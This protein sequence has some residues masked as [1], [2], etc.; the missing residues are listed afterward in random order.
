M[1]PGMDGEVA[2]F[3]GK[4][5][6]FQQ[7]I[8]GIVDAVEGRNG[9]EAGIDL[10]EKEVGTQVACLGAHDPKDDKFAILFYQG[11][12]K[13]EFFLGALRFTRAQWA[14]IKEE[15]DAAMNQQ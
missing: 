12:F 6:E 11:K 4:V 14:L 10:F 3:R 9:L 15:V 8:N 5:S 7:T 2:S 13:P 1:A